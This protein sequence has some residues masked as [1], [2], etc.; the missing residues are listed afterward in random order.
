MARSFVGIAEALLAGS[1]PR[2][3]DLQFLPTLSAGSV[4]SLEIKTGNFYG[5]QNRV[6]RNGWCLWLLFFCS[7]HKFLGERD[8]LKPHTYGFF[9]QTNF[10]PEESL[11]S[12][13]IW[14]NISMGVLKQ[15]EK[16]SN[17]GP[18]DLVNWCPAHKVVY[19]HI[20][21]ICIYIYTHSS[22]KYVYHI[23]SIHIISIYI[24]I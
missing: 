20:L 3:P 12:Q 13:S 2:L 6:A 9:L 17:K 10:Q 21:V 15:G 24:Y 5:A 7:E 23:T 19:V 4:Q 18:N 14:T 8:F 1:A 22:Q 11:Q 16:Q